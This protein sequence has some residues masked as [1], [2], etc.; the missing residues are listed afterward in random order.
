[1]RKSFGAGR[2]VAFTSDVGESLIDVIGRHTWTI[3]GMAGALRL[4]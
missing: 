1:M 2:N 3:T 4:P